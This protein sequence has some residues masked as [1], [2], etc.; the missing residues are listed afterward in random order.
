MTGH[1]GGSAK[2]MDMTSETSSH[3]RFV[4]LGPFT[5][6]VSSGDVQKDGRRVRI[7]DQPTRLLLALL[8]KPGEI[9]SREELRTKLW[10]D[11]TNVEFNHSIHAAINKLRQALGDSHDQPQFIETIPRRGYRLLAPASTVT[12]PEISAETGSGAERI[13]AVSSPP[14]VRLWRGRPRLLADA[15]LL[16]AAVALTLAVLH[17]KSKAKAPTAANPPTVPVS[18]PPRRVA[19]VGFKDLSS[20]ND[21]AWLSTA[22]AEML[23]TELG[24]SAG[25][26][27]V[28]AEDVAQMKRELSIVDADSYAQ[29]T[30]QRIQQNLGAELVVT[31]SL[32]RIGS[33]SGSPKDRIR[34]DVHLQ[35]AI[36]GQTVASLSETG[37]I[38]QLFDLVSDAG[39]QLRNQLG[40]APL[41]SSTEA[42]IRNTV[43]F[44]SA[45]QRL[46]FSG[47]QKLRE[48]D[49]LGARQ[50]LLQAVAAAPDDSLAH[51]ALSSALSASGFEAQAAQE[52]KLAFE[53]AKGLTY[54]QGL[55][56][57]GRYYDTKREWDRAEETYRRLSS[58]SPQTIEYPV[59]LAEIQAAEGKPLEAIATL[60]RLHPLSRSARDEARIYLVEA[61]A[62]DRSGDF[63]KELVAARAAAAQGEMANAPLVIA[64]ALRAQGVALQ[65]LGDNIEALKQLQAAEKTFESLNDPGGLVDALLDQGN[66]FSDL[67]DMNRAEANWSKSLALAR[68]TGNR[69]KEAT[70]SNNLGNI[71][72]TR[73]ET[74]RARITYQ[75]SY[76]LSREIDDKIGQAFS[77]MTIG[78][79]YQEECHLSRAEKSYRQA[80]QIATEIA[81]QEVKGEAQA[82]LAGVLADRGDLAQAKGIADEAL[83]V[84]QASG[85]KPTE[86]TALIYIGQVLAAQGTL[87]EAQSIAQK[88]ITEAD[89]LAAKSLQAG[90]RIL[91][92]LILVKQGDTTQAHANYQQALALE[93][94]ADASMELKETH[95]LLGEL[96]IEENHLSE[97]K[98]MLRLLQD[99]LGHRHD[100][101]TELECL[102]L[103]AELELLDHHSDAAAKTSSRAQMVSLQSERLELQLSAAEVAAQSA[104]AKNWTQADRL[105]NSALGRASQS[106][107]VACEFKVQFSQCDLRAKRDPSRGILCFEDLNTRAATKGFGLIARNAATETAILIRGTNHLL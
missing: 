54:K 67:G 87:K 70:A 46:Y 6:D 64:R 61:S 50:V 26:Q 53:L 99:D 43:P 23:S 81:N 34:F 83:T 40:V 38:A 39:M 89:A 62:Q 69:R 35:N 91:L 17:F 44:N 63:K 65:H 10:P 80:L 42:E 33:G 68:S 18:S 41:S 5:I 71:F 21:S 98:E 27:P 9:V 7:P 47:L 101:D 76:E 94:S 36:T 79:A 56:I 66:I 86:T 57:E 75:R 48:F 104:A 30:L 1:L 14:A 24:T 16:L 55:Q 8:E 78:D 4:Q 96:A 84:A 82:A 2:N 59:R 11:D 85:D 19:I 58:L 3:A 45:A 105:I 102:I 106:G 51:E 103:Q 22:F 90:G 52:A 77:L 88:A 73:G 92:G 13:A 60:D 15:A 29:Q 100:I 93:E 28:S 72:L 95:Y 31:G 32:M 74:E 25:L 97:A 107:C 20:R 12:S 37:T 49:H